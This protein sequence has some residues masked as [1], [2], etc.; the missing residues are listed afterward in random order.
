[1]SACLLLRHYALIVDL[2]TPLSYSQQCS[3]N[4]KKVQEI[5]A[6]KATM[7]SIVQVQNDSLPPKNSSSKPLTTTKPKARILGSAPGSRPKPISSRE[8]P[9]ERVQAFLTELPVLD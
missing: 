4:M 1:M 5:K 9:L 3:S 8:D 6:K 7:K 2:F